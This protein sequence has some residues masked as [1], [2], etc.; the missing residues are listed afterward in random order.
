MRHDGRANPNQ[1]VIGDATLRRP[2]AAARRRSSP[3]T[4]S[5]RPDARDDLLIGLQLTHSGRF[6]AA[7]RLG[8][9]GAARSPTTIRCSTARLA[10]AGVRVLTDDEL[11]GLIED[12][13]RAAGL[14][15]RAGFDFVDVKHCHGY[16]GHELL[17]ARRP[18]PGRYG[19]SLEN[20]TRFLRDDRR[21]HP[22]RGARAARSACASRAFDFVPFR[23]DAERPRRA[24]ERPRRATA[25]RFGVVDGSGLRASTSPSRAQL[26]RLLRGARRRAGV[27]HRGQPLLQPAHPAAGALPAVATATSRP[28]TRCVGVARQIDVDRASSS[29]ASPTLV[30]RRARPTPTCRSGCPTWRR[31][32]VR[33]GLGR[34]RRPRAHGAVLSR[35]AAPTC[36]P[37][38]R[39]T[40]KR[41]CRTFSDCTTGAAQ[42]ARLGLLSARLR[43]TP[44]RPRPRS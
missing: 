16:L 43:S 24:R 39:S 40:R 41:I 21:G 4:A 15:Q 2:R 1:L 9:P 18:R 6:C 25:T 5:V 36:S 19:G 7:Q 26:L 27:H 44:A 11:D 8:P 3:R 29:A 37:A 13:V 23:Q 20:R 30:V 12:F 33:D 22:R 10:R 28:K 38:G 35:A 34:L 31:R 17:S 14:A 32:C 42:G